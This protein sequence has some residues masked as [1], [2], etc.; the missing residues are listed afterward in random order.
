MNVSKLTYS[1]IICKELSNATSSILN[2]CIG[3]SSLR[4]FDSE[5][6]MALRQYFQKMLNKSMPWIPTVPLMHGKGNDYLW[7]Y[8]PSELPRFTDWEDFK[9]DILRFDKLVLIDENPIRGARIVDTKSLSSANISSSDLYLLPWPDLNCIWAIDHEGFGPWKIAPNERIKLPH[10]LSQ[11][12]DRR[13]LRIKPQITS[14][15]TA[16][17]YL[18]SAVSTFETI[19]ARKM[20]Y[21][22]KWIMNQLIERGLYIPEYDLPQGRVSWDFLWNYIPTQHDFDWP[23]NDYGRWAYTTGPQVLLFFEKRGLPGFIVNSNEINLKNFA[24]E[25]FYL[26]DWPEKRWLMAFPKDALKFGADSAYAP[27]YIRLNR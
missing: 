4:E 21:L 25:H 14:A 9:K 1:D 11:S 13:L 7:N 20:N 27:S 6:A 16:S 5:S 22:H 24:P 19:S 8:F 12:I 26:I 10:S 3:N 15:D 17:L 18:N 23:G 2:V